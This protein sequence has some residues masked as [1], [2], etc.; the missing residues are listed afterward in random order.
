MKMNHAKMKKIAYINHSPNLN[1]P[2][3]RLKLLE[4]LLKKKVKAGV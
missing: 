4:I 2:H 3:N 1:L